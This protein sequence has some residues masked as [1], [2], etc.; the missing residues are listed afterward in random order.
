MGRR[1]PGEVERGR[2]GEGWGAGGGG[3]CVFPSVGVG[4][5]YIGLVLSDMCGG[6]SVSEVL[7]TKVRDT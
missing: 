3:A 2:V 4:V 1:W 7:S 5:V 6:T